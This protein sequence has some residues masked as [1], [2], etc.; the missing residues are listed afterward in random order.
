MAKAFEDR[1]KKFDLDTAKIAGTESTAKT[2]S[3]ASTTINAANSGVAA[4][5]PSIRVKNFCPSIFFCHGHKPLEQTKAAGGR[6]VALIIFV[7]NDLQPGVN[8]ERTKDQEEKLELLEQ[9]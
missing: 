7:L 9:L 3:V 8:Q 6:F 1:I 4:R 5:R 2:T